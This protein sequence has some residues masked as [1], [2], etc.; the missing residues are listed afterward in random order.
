LIE[1]AAGKVIPLI[2]AEDGEEAFRRLETRILS[3][4]A[5]KT[6]IV[7]ATG[8]GVV[9]RPENLEL[10]RQNSIIIYLQ[11][12]LSELTTEGRPLSQKKGIQAL[13]KQ[14]LPLYKAWSD[15]SVSVE[16][17]IMRTITKIQEAI[18]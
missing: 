15:Y 13:A 11:R 14:R 16:A 2:F 5:K 3:E 17:D 7:I 10:L 12:E 1:R 8:G 6:G 18:V 4:Q 9:T